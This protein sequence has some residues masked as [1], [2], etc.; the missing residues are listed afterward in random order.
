L[1]K[2]LP[3]WWLVSFLDW[4]ESSKNFRDLP[5]HL[6]RLGEGLKLFIN[7]RGVSVFAKSDGADDDKPLL[8]VDSVDHSVS[9][10]FMFPIVVERRP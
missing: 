10:K 5:G 9:G 6:S 3:L 2:L 7:V 8:F 4:H 1:A